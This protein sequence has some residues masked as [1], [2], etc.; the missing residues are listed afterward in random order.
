MITK[1]LLSIVAFFLVQQYAIISDMKSKIDTFYGQQIEVS[2]LIEGLDTKNKI[3]DIEI[4]KLKDRN[5][6]R[7]EWV[8]NWIETWQPVLNEARKNS[9]K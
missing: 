6:S 9:R 3:Q 2:V 7:D 4:E 5:I 8:L 1:G